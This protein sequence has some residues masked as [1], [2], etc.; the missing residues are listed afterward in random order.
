[1]RLFDEYDRI[2]TDYIHDSESNYAYLN[3]TARPKFAAAR[4]LLE[5]WFATYPADHQATLAKNFS[6]DTSGPH[7]GAFFEMYCYTLLRAQGFEVH[8]EERVNSDKGNPID[9]VVGSLQQ[10]DFCVEATVV[11]ESGKRVKS[12]RQLE[13]LKKRLNRLASKR[14]LLLDVDETAEQ[15]LPYDEI[16]A[17]VAHWLDTLD[18]TTKSATDSDSDLNLEEPLSHIWEGHGWKLRFEIVSGVRNGDLI[19]MAFEGWAGTTPSRL[20]EALQKK[21]KQHKGIDV[22]YLIA[23]DV[24]GIESIYRMEDSIVDDLCGREIWLAN[25]DT[26]EFVE[27]KRSPDMPSRSDR[28]KGL[29]IGQAGPRNQHVS[30]ILLVNE[31]LP[32]SVMKQTPVLWHNPWATHPLPKTMW[33]GPHITLDLKDGKP[34]GKP[35]HWSGQ[36]IKEIF[37]NCQ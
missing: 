22:P 23:V 18:A 2:D 12:Q 7:I 8:V 16:V 32:W 21:A 13:E 30:G 14:Q 27:V 11:A 33:L 36:T 28:E 1:M 9:F 37:G 20:H 3:R 17:S 31:V 10:P 35:R 34:I 24:L 15:P 6:A 26:G 4:S 19:P 25:P 5:Q 29:W